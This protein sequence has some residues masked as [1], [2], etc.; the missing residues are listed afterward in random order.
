MD[1]SPLQQAL[2]ERG[3]L[4]LDGAMATE[5][6][7]HG[8]DLSG[9]LWS[10]RLLLDQPELIARVHSDYFEAG[11]DVAITAS[12]QASVAGFLRAGVPAGDAG[13][14]VVRSVELAREARD[15]FWSTA[16]ARVPDLLERRPRPLVATSVGPYGAVLADGS[17]YRGDYDVS[18]TDLVRFHR[19]RLEVLVGAG[20]EVL[21]CETIPSLSE[22][23]A[24]VEAIADWPD[25]RAW[26][27]FSAR[28][29]REISDGT[30][31]SACSSALHS[32]DQVVAVGVNCTALRHIPGLLRGLGSGTDKPLVVY[33]N[34]GEVYDAERQGWVGSRSAAD[35]GA[36][37][38]QWQA[39]GARLIGGCCRTSPGDIRAVSGAVQRIR[40]RDRVS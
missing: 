6:E 18:R 38:T 16:L 12:Y 10:A 1:R 20:V 19:E 21:A 25:V 22:A 35:F 24:L 29:E 11:A 33:P 5:L 23:E 2:H 27:S 36:L 17:E 7:R 31:I 14:L 40:D 9:G 32:A 15:R 30:P 8:A 28:N 4:V 3:V 26:V 13:R 34:S 37:A 39:D